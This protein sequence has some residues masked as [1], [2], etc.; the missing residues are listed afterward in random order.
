MFDANQQ[1]NGAFVDLRSSIVHV[2]AEKSLILAE[3]PRHQ[4]NVTTQDSGPTMLPYLC[5]LHC[6]VLRTDYDGKDST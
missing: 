2:Q 1:E 5:S 3:E 6:G 4:L